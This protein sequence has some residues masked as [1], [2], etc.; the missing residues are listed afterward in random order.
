MSVLGL[1]LSRAVRRLTEEGYEVETLE[2]R[3]RKGVLGNERRV[4]REQA[5][6]AAGGRPRVC[7]TYAVF[8][9]AVEE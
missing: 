1:E 9:T 4:I 3:S 2:V 7:L 6:P 5:L 8:S